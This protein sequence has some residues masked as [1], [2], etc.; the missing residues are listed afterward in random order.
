MKSYLSFDL[1]KKI[2]R[3]KTKQRITIMNITTT[4]RIR[5]HYV[6]IHCS[7][8]VVFCHYLSTCG[9]L[10]DPIHYF[11]IMAPRPPTLTTEQIENLIATRVAAALIDYVSTHPSSGDAGGSTGASG[12]NP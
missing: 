7:I 9:M 6:C 2:P 1:W 12:R 3:T 4:K 5:L 11:R 8:T 10:T